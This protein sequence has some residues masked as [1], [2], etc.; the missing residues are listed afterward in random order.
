MLQL[1]C[2]KPAV[3]F[4]F[5]LQLQHTNTKLRGAITRLREA[6]R[7]NLLGSRLLNVAEGSAERVTLQAKLDSV[8]QIV[9]FEN[10]LVPNSSRIKSLG[11]LEPGN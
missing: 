3:N 6:L 9:N 5:F 11:D 8:M 4:N 1:I 10:F 2:I 7:E